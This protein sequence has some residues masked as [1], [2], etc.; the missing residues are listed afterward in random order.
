VRCCELEQ[1]RG[2]PLG[3]RV[4]TLPQ[5][6]SQL[7][8]LEPRPPLSGE[9]TPGSTQRIEARFLYSVYGIP[10]ILAKSSSPCEGSDP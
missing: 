8:Q 4:V 1:M 6:V 9:L 5:Q 7:F 2:C 3:D 10:G